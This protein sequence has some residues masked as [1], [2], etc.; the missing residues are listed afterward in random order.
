MSTPVRAWCLNHALYDAQNVC[1]LVTIV[2]I[3]IAFNIISQNQWSSAQTHISGSP[4]LC[5][6]L[7]KPSEDRRRLVVDHAMS[8]LDDCTVFYIP[9][10][11]WRLTATAFALTIPQPVFFARFFFC[12]CAASNP[13]GVE[14]WLRLGSVWWRRRAAFVHVLKSKP[15]CGFQ[16]FGTHMRSFC[17][18]SIVHDPILPARHFS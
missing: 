15:S 1:V 12:R 11:Q 8:S 4:D 16:E 2:R 6:L 13:S 5:H 17:R 3:V 14:A 7:H 18:I 10:S 9:A